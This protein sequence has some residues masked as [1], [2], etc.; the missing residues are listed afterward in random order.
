MVSI[1]IQR[2][3]CHLISISQNH[4]TADDP[5]QFEQA[6]HTYAQSEYSAM[7]SFSDLSISTSGYNPFYPPS[8]SQRMPSPPPAIPQVQQKLRPAHLQMNNFGSRFLPHSSSQIHCLLPLMGG[9]LLLF[10]HDEGLSVLDLY[11]QE[12]SES[13]MASFKGPD[14]AQ[15]RLLW[16]GERF[17]YFL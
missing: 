13:G 16:T 3:L 17:V 1:I 8:E 14:D 15:A 9:K 5:V 12:I 6:T 2:S 10:G 11:P 7:Q 4:Y